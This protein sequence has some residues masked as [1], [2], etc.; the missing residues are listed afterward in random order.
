MPKKPQHREKSLNQNDR[1][2]AEAVT[3]IVT[4]DGVC[5]SSV[6]TMGGY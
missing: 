4:V 5:V 2:V 3:V 1:D 6:P